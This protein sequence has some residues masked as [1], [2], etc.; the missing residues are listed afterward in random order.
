MPVS[1]AFDDDGAWI[2]SQHGARSGWAINVAADSRVRIRQGARWRSGTAEFVPGDDVGARARTFASRPL[3][4]GITS[5]GFR[6]LQSDPISVRIT[7]TD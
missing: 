3:F 7:F 6:A 4:A 1:A 2:I 5:A